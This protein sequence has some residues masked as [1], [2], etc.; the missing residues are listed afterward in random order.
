MFISRRWVKLL[1]ERESKG[2]Q[3]VL[4]DNEAAHAYLLRQAAAHASREKHVGKHTC[5][6]KPM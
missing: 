4:K 6:I 3:A 2:P 1:T 5:R